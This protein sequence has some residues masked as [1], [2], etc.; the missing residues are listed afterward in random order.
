MG[1][2]M[3]GMAFKLLCKLRENGITAEMDFMEK[4]IKW[5]MKQANKY[6]AKFVAIIGEEEAAKEKVMLKNMLSGV[7]ELVSINEVQQKI[8]LDM[9]A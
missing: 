1:I 8:Q 9:E 7:Q 2:D 3:Q 5:Q 6:P 4:G